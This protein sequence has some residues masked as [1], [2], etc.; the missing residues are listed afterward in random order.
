MIFP[1]F[2]EGFGFPPLMALACG[3][4]VIA[5]DR[6]SLPEILGDSVRSV[7]PDSITEMS[8]AIVEFITQPGV[9][10]ELADKGPQRATKFRWGDTARLTWQI[11]KQVSSLQ[12]N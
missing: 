7:N 6:G 2:Y 3:I 4:P 9:A 1:S 8:E 5:S 11:Y 10:Q 12:T